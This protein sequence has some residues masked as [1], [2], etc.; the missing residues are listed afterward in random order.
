[1]DSAHAESMAGGDA[2]FRDS[3]GAT[4]PAQ[5]AETI[6]QSQAMEALAFWLQNGQMLPSLAWA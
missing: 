1:M 4:F 2:W 5:A 6:S 3:D